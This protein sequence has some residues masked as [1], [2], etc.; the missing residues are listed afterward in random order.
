MRTITLLLLVGAV[1][2][3][4]GCLA[5]D[6]ASL[7]GDDDATNASTN[8]TTSIPMSFQAAGPGPLEPGSQ[9]F[10]VPANAS[11]ILIEARWE[12]AA[13]PCG[14]ALTVLDENG[15]EVA[16]GEGQGEVNLDVPDPAPGNYTIRFSTNAPAT[17]VSGE[18][19]VTVFTGEIPD[20]FTA[21]DEEDAAARSYR[22]SVA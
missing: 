1:A 13:P 16:S 8:A 21:W 10:A 3:A 7:V 4:A 18:T 22:R 20:G 9:P 12:C 11:A 15:T 19:R 14:L 6:E 17:G 5:R 2:L